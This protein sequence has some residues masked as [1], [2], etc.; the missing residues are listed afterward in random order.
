MDVANLVLKID[1]NGVVTASKDLDKLESQSG[2]TERSTI[3][4]S[5][6]AKALG[7]ILAGLGIAAIAKSTLDLA[8]QYTSLDNKLKLVTASSTD[9]AYVQDE[10]LAL[11]NRTFTSYSA[12]V[13]LYSRLAQSSK[14]LS[15]DQGE[16]LQITENLNAAMVVSGATTQESEAA[17]IQLSQAFASG[18]L[19]GEEFNS[20]SE[21]GGEIMNILA[22]HLGVSRGELREMAAQGEL[23]AEVVGVALLGA[24]ESL[25]G[26]L[27][28][29]DVTASQAMV[30]LKN[31]WGDIIADT[32]TASGATA[33]VSGA[34]MALA[35]ALAYYKDD[36]S[37]YFAG[38]IGGAADAVEG[39]GELT[40]K[41]RATVDVM[42]EIHE[43]TGLGVGDLGLIGLAL[44][45][46]GPTGAMLAAGLLILN[47]A[48]EEYNLNL[49][50]AV[51]SYDGLAT[52]TGNLWRV[53]SGEVSASSGVVITEADRIKIELAALEDELAEHQGLTGFAQTLN[54]LAGG[55]ADQEWLIQ[56][57]DS[58]RSTMEELA[59]VDL[60]GMVD[61]LEAFYTV[62]DNHKITMDELTAGLES[63]YTVSGKITDEILTED[64][65]AM[66]QGLDAF[67]TVHPEILKQAEESWSAYQKKLKETTDAEE[68][69]AADVLQITLDG[70]D[71]RVDALDAFYI[72][73]AEQAAE[74]ARE[75]EARERELA[76]ARVSIWGDLKDSG[77]ASGQELYN[78]EKG[79]L[80]QQLAD[81]RTLG[82]DKAL[83]DRWYVAQKKNLDEELLLSNGSFLDG[84]R[85]A[86]ERSKEDMQTWAEFG[87]EVYENFSTDAK[88][89][90]SDNLFDVLHGEFDDLGDAWSA[91]WDSMVRTATDKLAD[92][93]VDWGLDLIG[94]YFHD[95]AWQIGD[96][97]KPD[98]YNAV[99][100]QG[101]MVIPKASADA[102]RAVLSGGDFDDI[103]AAVQ[104]SLWGSATD[105]VTAALT[106][107]LAA[108]LGVE[109]PAGALV[110]KIA[111]EAVENSISSLAGG[112]G[113]EGLTEAAG[114]AFAGETA[115][116]EAVA[117]GAIPSGTGA[118]EAY[119]FEEGISASMSGAGAAAFSAVA[120]VVIGAINGDEAG[121]IGMSAAGAFVGTLLGG[122]IGGAIGGAIGGIVGGL[123]FDGSNKT[124]YNFDPIVDRNL[125]ETFSRTSGFDI[126]AFYEQPQKT[127][128]PGDVGELLVYNIRTLQEAFNEYAFSTAAALDDADADIFLGRLESMIKQVPTIAGNNDLAGFYNQIVSGYSEGL[129]TV[130][131]LA[132]SAGYE[133]NKPTNWLAAMSS[134]YAALTMP[135]YPGSFAEPGSLRYP[136]YN[137]Y[138]AYQP[139]IYDSP[140]NLLANFDFSS[141]FADYS[142][143]PAYATG[144]LID[145]LMVPSGEDGFAAL[146]L[147]EGVVSRR[148]MEML[149]RINLGEMGN[150]SGSLER[151]VRE[152][153]SDM[154]QLLYAVAKNTGKTAKQLRNWD[155]GGLPDVRVEAA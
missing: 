54:D 56:R 47:E 88:A 129:E 125:D 28:L 40:P 21:Q 23:T 59:A 91:M 115:V 116:A 134:D 64:L 49:G 90:L 93:A 16:L 127:F 141:W 142:A 92:I 96:G 27:G 154:R 87:V 48:L 55:Q 103:V 86:H 102:I 144:G 104:G 10:L 4:L 31:N 33:A 130:S 110:N 151:E 66:V 83:L 94:E 139:T 37:Y 79:L 51:D 119:A 26:K 35:D 50:H 97:L 147:G 36:I 81:Y 108:A 29:M 111:A 155:I 60:S 78:F 11:S 45:G 153:R 152:L 114:Y 99:L 150:D 44:Y 39:I 18:V 72:Y 71:E 24:T 109:G 5:N 146:Q 6:A 118:A 82:V 12:S 14:D 140:A 135:N 100:Q 61:G 46:G 106:P 17:L 42:G 2:K 20:I 65:G 137:P 136:T 7:G 22:N 124:Y 112:A 30:T 53:A 75:S 57:I 76:S 32:N 8:D 149:D 15:F 101:E 25:T 126:A 95:G 122:P 120:A 63:F 138:T 41:I 85:L 128:V 34:I 67:Y 52:A 105:V 84:I 123:G 148:G 62:V 145:S 58:L 143:L 98:E 121:K 70:F 38:L 13:T 133:A 43:Y 19:R 113:L 9:L 68:K 69:L 131:D 80:D 89:A 107:D 73:S 77:I 132:L 3:S 74:D 117:S 1:S